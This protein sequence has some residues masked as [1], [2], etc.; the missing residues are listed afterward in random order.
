[1]SDHSQANANP[2][3]SRDPSNAAM[4]GD[5]ANEIV[6]PKPM[7]ADTDETSETEWEIIDLNS[8]TDDQKPE[9][10]ET[11]ETTKTD[12]NGKT[13]RE[14]INL[15]TPGSGQR[16]SLPKF[17][18]FRFPGQFLDGK[19]QCRVCGRAAEACLPGC[20]GA[21]VRQYEIAAATA[22]AQQ[23]EKDR[24]DETQKKH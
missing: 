7:L 1:M 12:E 13:D 15:N 21:E 3:S 18:L 5:R 19:P 22:H 14:P 17:I 11:D 20:F 6:D 8:P 2:S 9:L 4:D 24:K 16:I 23:Q 10:T